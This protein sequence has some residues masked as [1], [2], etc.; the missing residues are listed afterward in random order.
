LRKK[1]YLQEVLNDGLNKNKKRE[2]NQSWIG[3]YLNTSK[4][5]PSSPTDHNVPLLQDVFG[6]YH[7]NIA[8]FKE[9]VKLKFPERLKSQGEKILYK[10]RENGDGQLSLDFTPENNIPLS[11]TPDNFTK[12]FIAI[13]GQFKDDKI[14]AAR[15]IL[16][17]MTKE[18][19]ETT[20][21][22]MRAAGCTDMESYHS[23]L[24][25]ILYSSFMNEVNSLVDTESLRM[26]LRYPGR[27]AYERK[28]MA[29]K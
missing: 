4:I 11:N 25:E 21:S 20:L 10:E 22:A 9:A 15:Y 6:L 14:E 7:K 1:N 29:R 24:N 16:R 17:D 8:H 26:V 13:A 23:Y 3:N 12:N 19:R 2:P 18:D 27:S 5:V 28:G